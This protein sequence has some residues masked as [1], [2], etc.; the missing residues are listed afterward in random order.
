VVR[1]KRSR[2]PGIKRHL[3]EWL[4]RQV[5]RSAEMSDGA[6]EELLAIL[7]RWRAG[8]ATNEDV[9]LE[10]DRARARALLH[11][12]AHPYP[13]GT[14]PYLEAMALPAKQRET[15]K[16]T[17]PERFEES[18]RARRQYERWYGGLQDQIREFL[19]VIPGASDPGVLVAGLA[20]LLGIYAAQYEVRKIAWLPRHYRLGESGR[21]G[22]ILD[23]A[24]EVLRGQAGARKRGAAA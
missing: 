18:Q 16:Q 2:E 24:R 14:V 22:T 19:D 13:S 8:T 6:R 15:L 23:L 10:V 20:A 4:M 9:R 3:A 12:R 17:D 1:R 7:A 5:E 21:E 11:E